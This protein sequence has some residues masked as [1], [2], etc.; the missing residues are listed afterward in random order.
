MNYGSSF[1]LA[2]RISVNLTDLDQEGEQIFNKLENFSQFQVILQ[3]EGKKNIKA[4]NSEQTTPTFKE[5]EKESLTKATTT[6]FDVQH[7]LE[8]QSVL[9]SYLKLI[10]QQLKKFKRKMQH[11][12]NTI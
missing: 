10:R 9:R 4:L 8:Q 7:I 2:N 1:D 11:L 3:K 6:D 12:K 5:A